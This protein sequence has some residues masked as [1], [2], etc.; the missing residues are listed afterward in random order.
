MPD[1][2]SDLENLHIPAPSNPIL[3]FFH[4]RHLP[5]PLAAVSKPFCDLAFWL[6]INV[7]DS[8]ERQMALRKLLEAKDCAVRAIL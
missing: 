5:A 2:I 7:P 1:I 8:A 6:A 3:K 4:Y